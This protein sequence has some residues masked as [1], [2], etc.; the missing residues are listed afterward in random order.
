M[1]IGGRFGDPG[2]AGHHGVTIGLGASS[3]TSVAGARDRVDPGPPDQLAVGLRPNDEGAFVAGQPGHGTDD[4]ARAVGVEQRRGRRLVARPGVRG[5]ATVGEVVGRQDAAAGAVPDEAAPRQAAR[6]GPVG[7]GGQYRAVLQLDRR[8]RLAAIAAERMLMPLLRAPLVQSEYHER[9]RRT[10]ILD[11]QTAILQGRDG[12]ESGHRV[13][14]DR[15][16]VAPLVE[17]PLVDMLAF[18][19]HALGR[20]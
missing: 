19:L 16:I 8:P 6:V 7:P 20:G 14:T 10:P 9:R 1:A 11:D 18:S 4:G 13:P 15:Q 3:H 12:V 5:L 17:Q 2:R